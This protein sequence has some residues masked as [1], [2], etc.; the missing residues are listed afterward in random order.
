MLFNYRGPW[1][2]KLYRGE[3]YCQEES[4]IVEHSIRGHILCTANWT[5][6]EFHA[7]FY[8]NWN[9]ELDRNNTT[10]HNC[11]V[12]A[13][14]EELRISIGFGREKESGISFC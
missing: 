7:T 1:H 14:R 2:G 4:P 11:T 13:K 12:F 8:G 10:F 6:L 3:F 5:F 9:I